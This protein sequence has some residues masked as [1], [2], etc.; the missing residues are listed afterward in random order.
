MQA[1]HNLYT[2][3]AVVGVLHDMQT[4]L[5]V[6]HRRVPAY[7]RGAMKVA[8]TRPRANVHAPPGH[9]R[10]TIEG[11][12]EPNRRFL[13]NYHRNDMA[14][15]DAATALLMRRSAACRRDYK[16]A[17]VAQRLASDAAAA[18]AAAQAA[19]AR[20]QDALSA[21]MKEMPIKE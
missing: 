18:A 2:N 14:L 9:T 20:D 16:R 19:V 13:E 15:Y 6:L 3:Y 21:A 5:R 4:T 11:L 1:L 8:Q 10:R 12:S 17:M 7:F